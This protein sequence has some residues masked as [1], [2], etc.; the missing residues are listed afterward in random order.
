MVYIYIYT[1]I[2]LYIYITGKS[3]G[4]MLPKPLKFN[5]PVL[6]LDMQPTLGSFEG[7]F[8]IKNFFQALHSLK[9][10]RAGEDVQPSKHGCP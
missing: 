3:L 9:K 7:T 1:F 6:G 8:K 10:E 5:L 4:R 2:Y